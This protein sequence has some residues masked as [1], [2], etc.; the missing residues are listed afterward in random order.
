MRAAAQRLVGT[1]DFAAF[2]G[3]TSPG[4]STV[5]TVHSIDVAQHVIDAD[6]HDTHLDSVVI[7]V[8][9]NAFLRGMMRAFAGALVKVGQGRLAPEWISGVVDA[10]P[11]RSPLIALAP[12][13]G[14]HQWRVSYAPATEI[15]A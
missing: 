9:A 15:A 8:R 14:L 10:G 12:A 2:G 13:R 4:G 1:H 7:T 5:R 3:P 11:A 6:E